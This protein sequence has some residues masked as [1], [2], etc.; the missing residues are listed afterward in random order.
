MT[1]ALGVQLGT[2]RARAVLLSGWPRQRATTVDLPFDPERPHEAVAALRALVGTPRSIAVAIDLHLLRTKRVA[3]PALSAVERRNILRLEP[4]RFFAVRGE[5]LV[6][7]ICG[8]EGL[9]FAASAPAL[10]RWTE[11]IEQLAPV[12]LIEPTPVALARGL[13]DAAIDDAVIVLDGDAAG[14]DVAELHGGRVTRARRLFRAAL[15]PD[16]AYTADAAA[17]APPRTAF[18]DPWTEARRDALAPLVAGASLAALPTIRR[19]PGGVTI[20]GPFAA[21]YG[22]ALGIR[23]PPPVAETL[24]GVAHAAAVRRRRIRALALAATACVAAAT[25]ALATLGDRRD[26]VAAQLDAATTALGGRVA[27]ALAMQSELATLARRTAA[28][29]SVDADRPDPLRVLRGLSAALPPGA[30]V[31]QIHGVGPDWQVDGY[32]PS[33]SAVLAALGAAREF[34]DVHFLSAMTQARVAG[35]TYENFSLA[36]RFSPVH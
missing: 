5:E 31:R 35:Q 19:A 4:D 27:P 6:P 36:F 26:R 12:D 25:F 3:L 30:F 15:G 32:A 29:R 23:R 34:H 24:L 28:L 1:N 11:A 9:V 18:L 20:D 13:A 17:D 2:D 33:A 16:S 8:D 10:A 14:V 21:A 22:A 7:A